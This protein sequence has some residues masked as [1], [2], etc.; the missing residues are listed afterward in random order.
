MVAAP[1]F[2]YYLNG[3][4]QFGMR[5]ALDFEPFLFV[6]MALAV[7]ERMPTWGKALCAYSMVVGVWG[8]WYWN[9]FFRIF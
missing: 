2:L 3:L 1:S 4:V 7:R 8:V 9:T 5:H 6:L